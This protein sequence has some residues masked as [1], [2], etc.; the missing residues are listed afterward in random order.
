MHQWLKIISIPI[1]VLICG[2]SCQTSSPKN[3]PTFYND[4]INRQFWT[5]D[6]SPDDKYIALGVVDS[7]LRIYHST[8]LT[9]KDS[10]LIN[11][12]IHSLCYDPKG[13]LMA[14]ATLDKYVLL[15]DPVKKTSKQLKEKGGSRAIGWN[16]NGQLLAVGDLDGNI[17][18]WSRNGDLVRSIERN[19]AEDATGTTFLSLDWHPGENNFIATNSEILHVDTSGTILQTLEHPNKAAIMLC[20]QWHPS[21]NFFVIGDYGHNWEG[22]N[23]PSLL[24]FW[25]KNGK[26]IRSVEG[27]RAEYRNISWHPS[28][29]FLAT[30]SDVLRIWSPEGKLIHQSK[31]DN[32]NY[33]WGVDW[34]SEGNKIATSSR[35]KSVCIWNH[36]AQ[37]IK[38]LDVK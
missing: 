15:I 22:E 21:G 26:L 13:E 5:A 28:G 10:F 20:T 34:N 37:L 12:W 25:G 33:L 19:Y 18:L 38:R 1:I 8:T 16:F 27:S 7:I 4:S 14:V 36:K 23:V 17:Q 30:A 31:A 35:Y 29:N 3:S 32:S 6:W 11:S 2:H 24:H 9:L